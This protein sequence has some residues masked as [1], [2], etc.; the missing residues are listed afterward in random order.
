MPAKINVP[1]VGN[2]YEQ[3]VNHRV[4]GT[5]I[6]LTSQFIQFHC[7]FNASSDSIEMEIQP[8]RKLDYTGR[9][10]GDNDHCVLQ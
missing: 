10:A 2:L 9:V 8:R 7:P 3:F 1:L 6:R 5:I 4:Y